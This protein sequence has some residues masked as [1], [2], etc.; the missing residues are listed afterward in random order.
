MIYV[1][2]YTSNNCIVVR[3]KDTIR[4]YDSQPTNNSTN[5]YTDYFINSNYLFNNGYQ[6]FNQ[7][8]T[9]PTCVNQNLLTTNVFYRNDIDK[10]L[11]IFLILLIVCFW[12]PY[13]IISRAFGRWF[14]L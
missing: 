2:S 4:V 6:T 13:K 14:K 10:I 5:Y 3:D 9:I 12:F 1:P 8:S 11:I 7:Y